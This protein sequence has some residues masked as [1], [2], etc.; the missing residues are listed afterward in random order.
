[1][2]DFANHSASRFT[3]EQVIAAVRTVRI[4]YAGMPEI[5]IHDAICQALTTLGIAYRR[6]FRFGP[7]C[8]A[9]IWVDGI[10]IEVKKERPAR[11]TLWTQ[12]ERYASQE[13]VRAVVIVMERSVSLSPTVYGKPLIV[14][15]LNALWGIAL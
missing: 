6:E 9:D 5:E 14:V 11:A 15:S 4:A 2:L 13:A 8:R 1:M 3:V 7:R 10:V 12:V